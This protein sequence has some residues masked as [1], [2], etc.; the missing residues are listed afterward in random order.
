M[1]VTVFS[2]NLHYYKRKA[3]WFDMQSYDPAVKK[4]RKYERAFRLTKKFKTYAKFALKDQPDIVPVLGGQD[5]IKSDGEAAVIAKKPS[6]YAQKIILGILE[7]GSILNA[8]NAW[9]GRNTTV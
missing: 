4:L 1:S 6:Y 2:K 7:S 9:R 5:G 8:K 3:N